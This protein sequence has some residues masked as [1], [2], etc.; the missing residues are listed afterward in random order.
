[1]K[2]GVVPYPRYRS[3]LIHFKIVLQ[4][5]K[6]NSKQKS[7]FIHAIIITSTG[8]QHYVDCWLNW[9]RHKWWTFGVERKLWMNNKKSP[10]FGFDLDWFGVWNNLIYG[11]MQ[12]NINKWQ[13]KMEPL[14]MLNIYGPYIFMFCIEPWFL[15]PLNDSTTTWTQFRNKNKWIG[16]NIREDKDYKQQASMSTFKSII[17]IHFLLSFFFFCDCYYFRLKIFNAWMLFCWAWFSLWQSVFWFSKTSIFPRCLRF[18]SLMKS[19]KSQFK[20]SFDL[21]SRLHNMKIGFC[22]TAKS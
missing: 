1:M 12:V 10:M 9:Q 2:N 20:S 22:F 11:W 7:I 19:L 4:K 14:T 13:K 16:L 17:I 6:K 5:K 21:W 3:H 8:P 18:G 15:G